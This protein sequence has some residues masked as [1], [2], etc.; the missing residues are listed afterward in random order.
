MFGSKEINC[1]SKSKSLELS[2]VLEEE[3][4]NYYDLEVQISIMHFVIL[5]TFLPSD[6]STVVTYV[7]F[8]C[9]QSSTGR[10]KRLKA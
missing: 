3:T 2:Y 5:H 6:R 7:H 1:V 4:S 10:S 9:L 8:A